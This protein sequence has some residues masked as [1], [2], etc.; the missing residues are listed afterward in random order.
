MSRVRAVMVAAAV[1]ALTAAAPDGVVA[2]TVGAADQN[3]QRV[4]SQVQ[5]LKLTPEMK[6]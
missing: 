1:A 3:P 4:N 5:L 2:Q 6:V